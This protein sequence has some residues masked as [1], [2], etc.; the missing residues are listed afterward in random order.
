MAGAPGGAPARLHYA[1]I[2]SCHDL[3]RAHL[4]D[5]VRIE[6]VD[7]DK[8]AQNGRAVYRWT[9]FELPRIAREVIDKASLAPED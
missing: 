8:F 9:T 2:A 7:G 5:A 3:V 6:R 1:E 4:G